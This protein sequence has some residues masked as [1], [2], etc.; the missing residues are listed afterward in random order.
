MGLIV[1]IHKFDYRLGYKFS[2][3]A[4]NW[5]RQAISRSL[6]LTSRTIRIPSHIIEKNNKI[7]EAERRL[8]AELGRDA[9]IEEVSSEV[10]LSPDK[11]RMIKQAF[12]KPTSLESKIGTDEDSTLGDFVKDTQSQNPYEYTK[13][14][15][16]KETINK[17]FGMLNEREVGVLVLR[18][19]LDGNKPL[20]LE[21]VGLRYN[22]TRE[23][24]R[25]IESRVL[26]KLRDPKIIEMLKDFKDNE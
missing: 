9:T 17:I 20:T 21:E 7:L 6:D 13:K 2:T 1:A 3:Y 26:K 8:S 18:Y 22:L 23:R 12:V 19:G 15:N 10:K 14:K 11:I 5:I 25:Q 4:T 24:I 16:L